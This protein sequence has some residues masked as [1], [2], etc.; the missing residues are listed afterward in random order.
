VFTDCLIDVWYLVYALPRREIA[1]PIA[2]SSG[3]LRH[4]ARM[5]DVVLRHEVRHLDVRVP[6]LIN[7]TYTQIA[8]TV[9][10]GLVDRTPT[11]S[12]KEGSMLPMAP[13]VGFNICVGCGYPHLS[14]PVFRL[15][16]PRLRLS[17][18]WRHLWRRRR[19]DPARSEQVFR[20]VY[21]TLARRHLDQARC[22]EPVRL[23]SRAGR[24]AGAGAMTPAGNSAK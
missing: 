9:H 15:R 24:S 7:P 18:L 4:S 8:T 19:G 20:I 3:I 22:V 12:Q 2:T 17:H 5:C 11:A 13:G 23:L 1:P 21:N 6:R 10:I 16:R 14:L